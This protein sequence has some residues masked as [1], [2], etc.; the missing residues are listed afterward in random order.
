MLDLGR[1]SQ[2]VA[3]M[4]AEGRLVSED[5]RK[6]LDLALARLHLE[7]GRLTA[8]VDKLAVSKTSWLLAGIDE[9]L[10]HTYALPARPQAV[11]VVAT[12]GSQIAPSRHEVVPAFLINI[13]TVVL[14]YGTGERAEL[15]SVPTLFYREEDLYAEHGGQRIQVT[16]ELLGMRRTIMEFQSLLQR[17]RA[18][19]SSGHCTCALVDGSLILWQLE[20]K[21]PDYQQ[22]TLA[23]YLA[24]LEAARQRHIP[25]AGYISRPRS[26][27]VLNALR[28]GLCP[29]VAPNCDRCPYRHLPKL[30][31][32]E[33][34]GLSDRS[35]FEPLLE[36]GE[37]TPVFASSSR[38]LNAYG[39]HRIGF[40]YLNVGAEI[41]R[42]EVPQWVATTPALLDLVH[43]VAYDQAQKGDGYPVAL[44][45]AH[46][47]AV[48]RGAERDLF[49]DMVTA[50]LV[51][52]GMR[53]TISPKNLRKRRMT[54]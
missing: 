8:F 6:R 25:V 19:Q 42:I 52:R 24:Y 5:L 27:D 49:Y 10:E 38:I 26:R 13:A 44:A 20:G 47:H 43:A 31:C 28:V 33:I 48:V 18:A 7:S 37:R 14:H 45:E 1:V 29:E 17:A 50:V 39:A 30:P 51:R 21:P 4:A 40:F 23:S 3:Y 2:Q 22:P 34:E 53:A 35:L 46:Q 16:G 12:D 36:P 15:S 54:V 9:S 32:A 41:A 11:T